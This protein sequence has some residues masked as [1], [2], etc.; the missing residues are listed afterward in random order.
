[1]STRANARALVTAFI[2]LISSAGFASAAP[3]SPPPGAEVSRATRHDTS[4]ALRDAVPLPPPIVPNFL[5]RR[6]MRV[7]PARIQG[8]AAPADPALQATPGAPTT[9]ATS[10]NFEGISSA[11]QS[12]IVDWVLPP[13]TNGAIGPNHYVQIVN[14]TFA[15]FQRNGTKIYGPVAINTLWQNFGQACGTR[16]DGD[17][18]VL[19]DHLADRWFISQLA[20]PNFPLGPFYQCI[21][22]STTGDPLGAYHRYEFVIS[23]DKLNDYPKF[24]VWPDGYYLSVNQYANCRDNFPFGITCDWAGPRAVVFERSQMLVGQAA[25]MA[26]FDK[27]AA[28]RGGLLPSGLDGPAPAAGTP[29]YF[30]QVDDGAWFTPAVADRLQIWAFQVD[31]SVDPPVASFGPANTADPD[32]SALV[33]PTASFDSNMCNYQPNCIPQPGTDIFGFPS[34]AVDALS[35]RL[36]HRLQYRGF[37]THESIVATHTVDAGGDRAGMRW[38]E[39]RKAPGGE[40]TIYQQ[41]TFAPNDGNHRWMGSIAMDQAGNIALGYSVSSAS[42][43]P[44]IR[45]V[46]RDAGDPP[47]VMGTEATIVAGS[48]AQLD[49]SGRWGDYSAM[50]V[51]PTDDCTFW[52]TQEYYAELEYFYGR[53]WRTRIA[54]F[55]MPSCGAQPVPS[56]SIS[57]VTVTE[58]NAG[59]VAAVFTVSLS[60]SSASLVTVDYATANGS[61]TAGSDYVATSGTLTFNPGTTSQSVTVTVNG[62]TVVEPDETFFVNLTNPTNATLAK[63]QGQGTILNDDTAPPPPSLS[64]SDV[65]VTEGNSG[66]VAAVFTVSLSASSTNPVTVGYATA[67]GSA[68]AGSDYVATS[69]TLTF[70]PGTTALT[71]TVTVNGDTVVEPDETFFVN[72]TNPTNATLA[73]GQGQGTILND[74]TA[75]PPPGSITV[76]NPNGRE[77]WKI[78]QSRQI[79]WTSSGVTGAVRIDLARNG[80]NFTEAIAAS[81]VNDGVDVWSVTGPATTNARIR[82]C[83]T[84]LTVCH[85]SDGVFRIH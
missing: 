54:S 57:D 59:T 82:I 37:P 71:I 32:L 64:I 51:D 7:P 62:D 85:A 41:G 69:G 14:T 56:L 74:D 39:L 16:N 30:I 2:A 19:Y 28:N 58:G 18:T 34:P 78:G 67:N 50:M 25:R 48:G 43:W 70:N 53:N 22:V 36:M 20:I 21:A 46:T 63:G 73:K 44:S 52:Y 4:R 55:K 24:G 26:A 75:P 81:T 6:L 77:N 65:T 17:P 84:D 42:T 33:L 8:G 35:D 29:N 45:Y 3:A 13:D 10:T 79:Q 47:G 40:W 66:T 27:S 9:P 80:T 5:H 15:V 61:A 38:Y 23:P 31:W 72:L 49:S 12:S 1:M 68:T 76:V 83:T 60:A 11:E